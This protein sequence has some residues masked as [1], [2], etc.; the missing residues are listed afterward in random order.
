MPAGFHS[1]SHVQLLRRRQLLKSICRSCRSAHPFH[2]T[3]DKNPAN[4]KCCG[5]HCHQVPLDY[6]STQLWAAL[7]PR[8]EYRT[9]FYPRCQA[10][11]QCGVKAS[12]TATASRMPS[13]TDHAGNAT[14]S[15]THQIVRLSKQKPVNISIISGGYLWWRNR[16]P[17][18]ALNLDDNRVEKARSLTGM[19]EAAALGRRSPQ[20]FADGNVCENIPHQKLAP[21]GSTTSFLSWQFCLGRVLLVIL[22]DRCRCQSR[23]LASPSQQCEGGHSECKCDISG[24]SF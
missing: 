16:E 9:S 8:F 19:K 14:V 11:R 3:N 20:A 1:R 21:S 10:F 6:F 4:T 22:T 18:Y 2:L 23:L 13:S 17:A 7:P 12:R 24:T 5:L 15:L